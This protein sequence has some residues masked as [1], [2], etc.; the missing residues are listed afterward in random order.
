MPLNIQCGNG[1]VYPLVY[2][3]AAA[4]TFPTHLVCLYSIKEVNMTTEVSLFLLAFVRC[5]AQ[6]ISHYFIT[7]ILPEGLN[8]IIDDVYEFW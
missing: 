6:V 5:A 1:V 7:N 8:H 4:A 2:R 3:R